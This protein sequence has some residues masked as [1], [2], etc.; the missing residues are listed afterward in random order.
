MIHSIL[1]STGCALLALACCRSL[2]A[3]SPLASELVASNLS[4]PIFVTAP[5][6]DFDRIF[7]V[8]LGTTPLASVR[9]IDIS[10]HP[11]VVQPW[12]YVTVG[13]VV[14][15]C[16]G[17][18]LSLAFHPQFATNGFFY[19]FYT[20]F[21]TPTSQGI[22]IVRY[23]ALAPFATSTEADLGS[24]TDVLTIAHTGHKGGWMG[25][26]P[27]GYLYAAI[28][29][30]G[31]WAAQ[32]LTK[33]NGKILRIDVDGDDFPSDPSRNY[34]IP[35]ANPYAGS[36][37]KGHSTTGLISPYIQGSLSVER[38][39]FFEVKKNTVCK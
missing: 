12:P 21:D 3:Q 32:D 35:P 2:G 24:K 8:E 11:P 16:E 33:L 22:R 27:D 34:A 39:Y 31:G 25:F 37:S 14:S 36:G 30:D 9:V 7:V 17:G 23:Q 13:D 1:R 4:D 18:L 10:Q 15:C 26:G 29:D 5:P 38:N 28:G 6:S 19:V 20:V